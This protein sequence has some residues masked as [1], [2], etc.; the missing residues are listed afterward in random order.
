MRER[1]GEKLKNSP[2]P[3]PPSVLENSANKW[4]KV[5]QTGRRKEVAEGRKGGR[6]Y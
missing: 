4:Q 2:L 5:E 1:G 6:N 3:Y